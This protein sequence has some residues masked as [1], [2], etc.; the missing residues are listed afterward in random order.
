MNSYK[1]NR[2]L[3]L[4]KMKKKFMLI[5]LFLLTSAWSNLYSQGESKLSEKEILYKE[6]LGKGR[7][8]KEAKDYHQMIAFYDLAIEL[9]PEK[10]T[11]YFM[12]AWYYEWTEEDYLSA[13]KNYSLAIAADRNYSTAYLRRADLYLKLGFF[14]KALADATKLI[15]VDEAEKNINGNEYIKRAE[16]KYKMGFPIGALQDI[17]KA[18]SIDN[19]AADAFDY[20]L[21]GNIFL[22]LKDK[23]VAENNYLQA[24]VLW[25]KEYPKTDCYCAEDG[26]EMIKNPNKELEERLKLEQEILETRKLSSSI[27]VQK[28]NKILQL[29]TNPM[30]PKEIIIQERNEGLEYLQEIFAEMD[31]AYPNTVNSTGVPLDPQ[32]AQYIK[33]MGNACNNGDMTA[34]QELNRYMTSTI[35]SHQK[36]IEIDKIKKY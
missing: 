14:D 25:K 30:E 9:L 3:I 22:A 34:C 18:F 32:L 21:R 12:K 23:E 8:A 13:I 10:R 33:S 11:A 31:R 17:N 5:F 19:F 7:K 24:E 35:N 20:C 29:E 1:I 2:S 36:A 6:L 28:N 4:K 27:E 26:L 15:E 16:I